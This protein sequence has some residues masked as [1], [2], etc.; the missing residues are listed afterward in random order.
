METVRFHIADNL[1]IFLPRRLRKASDFAHTFSRQAPVKD[2]VESLG[3]PH[4]EISHL[5]VNEQSVDF[6][7]IVSPGDVIEV[8]ADGFVLSDSG[9]RALRPVYVGRPRFVL[10][11]HLGRLASYLR[12]L[13]FDTLYRND[14]PDPELAQI[15]YEH[16]RILLSRDVGLLKRS[17][18]TYGYYVRNTKPKLR[19]QEIVNYFHLREQTEPF[20]YCLKC[21]GL[22]KQVDKADIVHQLPELTAAYYDEFHMCPT[23]GQV[24][25]KGSHYEK[26][27]AHL[28]DLL[29]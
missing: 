17:I 12:M 19:I 6:T 18:V 11:T 9:Y 29:M 23:C 3:V 4:C 21:N 10:D 25:W 26:M 24:Y 7:Y 28:S 5:V 14:Y 22:L 8:Y 16:K 15:A 20:K 1:R 13:G 27:Q 2:M